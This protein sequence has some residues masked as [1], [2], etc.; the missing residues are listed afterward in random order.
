MTTLEERKK[1]EKQNI[2]NCI[3]VTKEMYETN[4]ELIA[5]SPANIYRNALNLIRPKKMQFNKITPKALYR[6]KM[7]KGSNANYANCVY[8]VANMMLIDEMVANHADPELRSEFRSAFCRQKYLIKIMNNLEENN[9]TTNENKNVKILVS[10][11]D[12]TQDFEMQR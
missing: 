5:K 6:Y 11:A 9:V 3:S 4:E 10:K 7:I 2:L 1:I 12:E 8:S